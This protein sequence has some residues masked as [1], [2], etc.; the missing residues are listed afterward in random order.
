MRWHSLKAAWY[1]AQRSVSWVKRDPSLV[2]DYANRLLTSR[3]NEASWSWTIPNDPSLV[4]QPIYNQ[5]VVLD[6]AANALG[7]VLSDAAG[8]VLGY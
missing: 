7:A 1:S 5:A 4:C 3:G 6:L 2:D 8:G